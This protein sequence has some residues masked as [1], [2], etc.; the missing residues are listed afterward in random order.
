[1]KDSF[2]YDYEIEF[3]ESQNDKPTGMSLNGV[4][5]D[6]SDDNTILFTR[7]YGEVIA[8][9]NKAAVRYILRVDANAN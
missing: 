5:M 6:W 3:F 1:M 4:E 8:I 7:G 9:V 2:P